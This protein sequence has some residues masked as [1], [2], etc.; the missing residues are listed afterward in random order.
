MNGNGELTETENV[1][2]YV[3]YGVRTKFL[4]MNVILTYCATAIYGN[5]YGNGCGMLE[6]G[7]YSIEFYFIR[8]HF[9]EAW[10]FAH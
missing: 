9:Y 10:S 7:K 1:I 2:F 3:S 8:C 4:Q 6:I 5:G